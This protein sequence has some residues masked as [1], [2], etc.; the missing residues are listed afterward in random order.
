MMDS[1]IQG[2]A[3]IW[4]IFA[5]MLGLDDIFLEDLVETSLE[6]LS[7]YKGSVRNQNIALA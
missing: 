3:V 7:R 6:Q 1:M 4:A 5:V 2:T